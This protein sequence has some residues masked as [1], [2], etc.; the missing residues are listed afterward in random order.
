MKSYM[1]QMDCKQVV[2]KKGERY[3]RKL[4]F[5]KMFGNARNR[6]IVLKDEN[7]VELL[8]TT[9]DYTKTYQRFKIKGVYKFTVDHI[10]NVDNMSI[11]QINIRNMV[12]SER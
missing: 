8:W 3:E 12:L 11:P 9:N 5:I 2:F 1:I 6:S 7:G 10:I 4:K